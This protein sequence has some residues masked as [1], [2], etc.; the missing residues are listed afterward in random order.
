MTNFE[1]HLGHIGLDKGHHYWLLADG[2]AVS[3]VKVYA[4]EDHASLCDIETREDSRN[5]G[6]SKKILSLVAEKH[7]EVTHCG[8]YTPD[9]FAYVRG[10]IHDE[11]EAVKADYRPMNFVHDWGKLIPEYS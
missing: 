7:G 10:R 9:G 1:L 6:Y 4:R 5:M 2:E 11:A 8:G 3:Y